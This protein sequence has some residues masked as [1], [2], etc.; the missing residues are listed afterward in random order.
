MP[1]DTSTILPLIVS[2]GYFGIFLG[3][4]ISGEILLLLAGA[5]AALG[6]LKLWLVVVIAVTGIV[7]HDM[8]WYLLGRGGRNLEFFKNIGKKIIDPSKYYAIEEKFKKHSVLV[9]LFLRFVYGFR[10]I[11]L[12]AAGA[13]KMEFGKFSFYTFV[14][15]LAWA[16]IFVGLGHF[17]GQSLNF[18]A[19]TIEELHFVI[20]LFSAI[21]LIV[22]IIIHFAR[23]ALAKSAKIK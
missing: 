15:S 19:N 4:I 17:F 16:M 11:S 7:L 21:V 8:V 13:S 20:P 9:I 12:I 10:A 14:G 1:I 18:L 3:V 22:L 5:L 23:K 2:F 6:Y